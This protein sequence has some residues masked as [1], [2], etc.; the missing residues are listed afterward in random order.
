MVAGIVLMGS[1]RGCPTRPAWGTTMKPNFID[2]CVLAIRKHVF[3]RTFDFCMRKADAG[4]IFETIL[5]GIAIPVL[6]LFGTPVMLWIHCRKLYPFLED[7][8]HQRTY[9]CR[10]IRGETGVN[11]RQEGF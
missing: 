1:D 5:A 4:D 2:K 10:L 7:A 11:W 9:S 6:Y 3:V 8:Q